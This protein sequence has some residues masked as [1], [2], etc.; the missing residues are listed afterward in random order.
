MSTRSSFS[1]NWSSR[2][3]AVSSSLRPNPPRPPRPAKPT[4]RQCSC[5]TASTCP[6]G[7]GSAS[8][9]TLVGSGRPP[10]VSSSSRLPAR[11]RSGATP[12]VRSPTG[13]TTSLTSSLKL[14]STRA[15]ASSPTRTDPRCRSGRVTSRAPTRR[16]RRL[17][18]RRRRSHHLP[19]CR[20]DHSRRIRTATRLRSNRFPD[21]RAGAAATCVTF[22]ILPACVSFRERVADRGTRLSK[23]R[24]KEERQSFVPRSGLARKGG[25]HRRR[26]DMAERRGSG[27]GEKPTE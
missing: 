1:S 16:L 8:A 20:H 25:S 27:K 2:P 22:L 11:F 7:R 18:C 26:G 23:S 4:N 6:T 15:R 9:A 24:E 3:S 19:H 13:P 12:S 17:R 21:S 10:C 5:Q 14:R